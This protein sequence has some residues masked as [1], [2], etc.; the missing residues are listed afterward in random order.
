MKKYSKYY[1]KALTN[2]YLC[3]IICNVVEIDEVNDI[4]KIC[5][6]N[7]IKKIFIFT[8]LIAMMLSMVSCSGAK[9]DEPK[10]KIID[11]KLTDEEYAFLIQKG[12]ISLVESINAFM[13]EIKADGTFNSLVSKYFEGKGDKNGYPVSTGD[14]ENTENNFIVV[15]NCPFEPFEYMGAD[16]KIYGLDIEIAAAYAEKMGL[17]LVIKNID[18]EAIFTQVEAGYADIGMAGITI[19]EGRKAIFDFTTPYYQASQKLIVA[20]DNTDFDNCKTALDVEDVFSSLENKKIG[21]QISTTG[22]LYINGNEDWGFEGFSNIRG[23]SYPTAQ[24]A[25]TDLINGNLYAVVVDEAPGNMIIESMNANSTWKAK[26]VNFFSTISNKHYLNVFVRGLG[27]TIGI[28]VVGLVIGILIGTIIAIV[29]I[30]P[31]Y[32]LI[33]KILDKICSIYVTIFR[34]TPIVAQLLI[35]YYVIIPSLNVKIGAIPVGMIV[36]GMNSGAY[37]SEIMRGGINSVDKGQMEAGRALGMTYSSTMIKIVVPQAIKN[38]LPTLGNEFISLIK[39]TS[40]LSFIAVYDLY[41]SLLEVGM[42]NY[43]SMVPYLMMGLIYIVLVLIISLGVKL[44]E[45]RFAKSD[46]H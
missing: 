43:D 18:F 32:K 13:A 17:E 7:I 46:R 42:V 37:V 40:V 36:F 31:K 9:N 20:Y 3:D 11:I 4:V 29:R 23:A 26:F 41:K 10:V 19:S 39:E 24:L 12:N 45:R 8:M 38:I 33:Y 16:G 34:G 6:T 14:V 27:N 44:F 22:E 25:V 30:A 2:E 28:A 5:K 21:Y 1:K 35:A 15:T